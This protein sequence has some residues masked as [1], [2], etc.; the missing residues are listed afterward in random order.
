M[1][2]T[3]T[4]TCDRVRLDLGEQQVPINPKSLELAGVAMDALS[5]QIES[6]IGRRFFGFSNIELK[7]RDGQIVEL[8]ITST[9]RHI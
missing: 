9:Q 2:K 6:L 7:W 3:D 4:V 8:S 1:P 5:E